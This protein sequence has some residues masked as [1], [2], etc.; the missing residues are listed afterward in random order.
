MN[1]VK[2]SLAVELAGDGKVLGE[3]LLGQLQE[4][5]PVHPCGLRTAQ[6]V[7]TAALRP[8]QTATRQPFLLTMNGA[9]RA[10]NPL[11]RS[12]APTTAGSQSVVGMG[13]A[14][15]MLD[16]IKMVLDVFGGHKVRRDLVG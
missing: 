2:K 1:A 11:A 6:W 8:K 15:M 3:P 13:A 5:P 7:S 9:S 4:L 16:E 14:M 12:H 10:P